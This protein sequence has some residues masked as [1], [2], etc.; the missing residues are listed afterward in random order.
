MSQYY[1]PSA[2]ATVLAANTTFGERDGPIV[3]NVACSGTEV[4]LTDCVFNI[5]H[6]CVH[7]DDVALSCMA[8]GTG[9]QTRSHNAF[10]TLLIL[11]F[12]H[13][14]GCKPGHTSR[15]DLADNT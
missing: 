5:T 11:C 3:A 10:T 7:D 2:G 9:K 14:S 1:V 13:L 8:T 6:G 12:K 4:Q 15:L